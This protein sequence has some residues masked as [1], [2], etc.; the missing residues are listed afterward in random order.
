VILQIAPDVDAMAKLARS[1]LGDWKNE[2][3]TG[4]Q[5]DAV[6]ASALIERVS[7]RVDARA[8]AERAA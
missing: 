2:L 1:A 4:F 5:A 6:R 8:C 3:L 7:D